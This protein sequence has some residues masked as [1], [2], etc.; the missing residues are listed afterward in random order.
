[1]R[2][3]RDVIETGWRAELRRALWQWAAIGVGAALAAAGALWLL[4]AALRRF[5]GVAAGA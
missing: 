4:V 2:A 5:L 3:T 1:M